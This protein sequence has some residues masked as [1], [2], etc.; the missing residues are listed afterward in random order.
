VGA[1][2]A[3][4]LARCGFQTFAVAH[5][6]A[7][8]RIANE[9]GVLQCGGDDAQGRALHT[10]HDGEKFVAQLEILFVHCVMRR[11]QPAGAPLLHRMERVA[12]GGLND[13]GNLHLRVSRNHVVQGTTLRQFTSKIFDAELF[14]V[15]ARHL[16]QRFRRCVA[17]SVKNASMPSMPSS[18]TVAASAIVP[19]DNTATTEQ[20]PP[21]GK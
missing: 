1:D 8:M 11:E 13:F 4:A 20:T 2:D 5:G 12:R 3:V 19:L 10:E 18:P 6:D 14:D 15:G 9:S 21:L 16:Q 17:P 7:P